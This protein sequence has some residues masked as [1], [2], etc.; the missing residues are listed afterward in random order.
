ME[1]FYVELLEKN[2]QIYCNALGTGKQVNFL[3]E[4]LM[5]ALFGLTKAAQDKEIARKGKRG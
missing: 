1:L 5:A 2:A 3:P 4:M